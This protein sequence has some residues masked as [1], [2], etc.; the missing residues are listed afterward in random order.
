[1]Y[2]W[3]E[4]TTEEKKTEHGGNTGQ[5]TETS[6]LLGPNSKPEGFPSA[7]PIST[8]H[9][10]S[11]SK[12]NPVHIIIEVDNQT[13]YQSICY[14]PISFLDSSKCP[15]R[16]PPHKSLLIPTYRPFHHHRPSPSSPTSTSSSPAST[17][18]RANINNNYNPVHS[19]HRPKPS[20]SLSPGLNNSVTPPP[21][22]L[23]PPS[24][25]DQQ[26]ATTPKPQPRPNLQP[27]ST[28][29][30][31][32]QPQQQQPHR[33]PPQQPRDTSRRAARP[34][35]PKSCLRTSTRSSRSWSRRARPSRP[36]R[37]WTAAW[38]S[39]RSKSVSCSARSRYSRLGWPSWVVLRVGLLCPRPRVRNRAQIRPCKVLLMGE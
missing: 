28:T 14:N 9:S 19:K 30:S 26:A 27:T 39:R 20:P 36:C 2:A 8:F 1:M 23:R 24:Q 22:P 29:T 21:P 11:H 6:S 38:T 35:T 25:A 7:S 32:A 15:R 37:T 16:H 34:S 10:H 31:P 18:F 3:S 17:S 12:Q 5:V 4:L 33:Q 13:E